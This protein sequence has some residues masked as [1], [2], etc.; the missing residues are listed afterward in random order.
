MPNP[1]PC[2]FSRSP[3]CSAPAL[4]CCRCSGS[5][6]QADQMD[7]LAKAFGISS[8]KAKEGDAFNRELQVC[9]LFW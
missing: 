9:W 1:A 3:L 4:S 6:L 8:D 2:T 7:K 5:C